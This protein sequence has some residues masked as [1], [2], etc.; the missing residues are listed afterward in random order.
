MS[1]VLTSVVRLA[2]GK[3]IQLGANVWRTSRAIYLVDT[4]PQYVNRIHLFD[5]V[6]NSQSNFTY[7]FTFDGLGPPQ[8]LHASDV[9]SDSLRLHWNHS[10]P[11]VTVFR[12]QYKLDQDFAWS[13]LEDAYRGTDYSLASLQSNSTFNFQ[14]FASLDGQ[15][16]TTGIAEWSNFVFSSF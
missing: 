12:I 9:T 7:A 3:A 16:E 6:I 4:Q 11:N 13:S 15:F 5:N 1:M 10:N 2:D 8:N 14:V